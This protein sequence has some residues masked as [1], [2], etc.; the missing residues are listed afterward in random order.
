MGKGKRVTKQNIYIRITKTGSSSMSWWIHKNN[1]PIFIFPWMNSR[2][3][4]NF[5]K[6]T[7]YEHTE[8]TFSFT[9]CR[10]PFDRAVSSWAFLSKKKE[11]SINFFDFL[12]NK[13]QDMFWHNH[14]RPQYDFIL[15]FENLYKTN[16]K[17]TY[18]LENLNQA[19]TSLSDMHPQESYS[20]FPKL[21]VSNLK[22]YQEFYNSKTK[23]L[24][25]RMFE[26]DFEH[27]NYSSEL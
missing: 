26:K 12:R 1:F 9:L 15:N 25:L 27:F 22:P 3:N 20:I 2:L 8:N 11:L 16:I 21:R 10:N 24:V 6:N 4:E 13:P 19:L 17:R 18:K 23:D 5:L 7:H 14:V